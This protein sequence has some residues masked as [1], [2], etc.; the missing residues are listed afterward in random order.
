MTSVES[1]LR[2]R[3]RQTWTSFRQFVFSALNLRLSKI[4]D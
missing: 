4:G 1:R 2:F 3:P